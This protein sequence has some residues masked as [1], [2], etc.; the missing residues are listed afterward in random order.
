VHLGDA[1]QVLASRRDTYDYLIMD[2]FTGDTSP[3]H[4]LSREALTL[5]RA[6]LTPDGVAAFNFHGSLG[7]DRRMTASFARTLASVFDQVEMY[8]LFDTSRG[9]SWGNIVFVAYSGAARTLDR[10][11]L[12]TQAIDPLAV[13][14]V[15]A[16]LQG[17]RALPVHPQSIVLTDDHNPLDLVDVALKERIRTAVLRTTDR[18]VLL[19]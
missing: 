8:P 15:R 17:P 11:R 5:V 14:E 1:R 6:R 4:L 7:D 10:A 16:A 3:G 9:E 13:R 12:A 18:G 19:R 2:A